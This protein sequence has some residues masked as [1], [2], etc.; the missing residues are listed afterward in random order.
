VQKSGARS[1][2]GCQR[3]RLRRHRRLIKS[4]RAIEVSLER[5][6][7]RHGNNRGD[8]FAI[9][10]DGMFDEALCGFKPAKH[11]FLDRHFKQR[12]R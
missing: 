1:E 6:K 5:E 12:R 7:L 8:V 4:K 2:I 10:L 3:R 9:E 11:P